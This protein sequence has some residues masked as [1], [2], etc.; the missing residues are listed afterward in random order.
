MSSSNKDEYI[1]DDDDDDDYV[2]ITT[3]NRLSILLLYIEIDAV[4][5]VMMLL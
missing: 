2:E 5:L 3:E 4:R 1:D